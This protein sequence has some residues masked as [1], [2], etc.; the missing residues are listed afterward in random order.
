AP[1]S[2]QAIVGRAVMATGACLVV[3]FGTMATL[4]GVRAYNSGRTKAEVT[5]VS[6][7]GVELRTKVTESSLAGGVKAIKEVVSTVPAAGDFDP[8][9]AVGDRVRVIQA[10]DA[11]GTLQLSR[12][13]LV[14]RRFEVGPALRTLM[15]P[16]NLDEWLTTVGLVLFAAVCGLAVAATL[17]A[18][19]GM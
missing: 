8:L 5:Q 3:A 1:L 2:R 7:A 13:K 15:R 14:E 16:G 9:P 18:R 4:G 12:K 17:V 11:S 6:A 10:R 19:R